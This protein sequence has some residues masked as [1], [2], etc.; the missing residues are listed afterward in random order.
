MKRTD[1]VLF[2]NGQGIHVAAD[3]DGGS[4]R[5]VPEEAD[6]AGLTH[7]RTMGKAEGLKILRHHP[8]RPGFLEG[9]LGVHVQVSP[10]FDQPGR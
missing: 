7:F 9:Q 4:L 5:I 3:G 10:D 2:V 1:V 8:G 6:H